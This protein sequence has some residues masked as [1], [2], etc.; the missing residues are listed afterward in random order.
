VSDG[1]WVALS[2]AVAQERALSVTANN[3]ANAST[4]GFRGDR[5]S[6]RET[7]SQAGVDG[8][9]PQTLRFVSTSRVDYDESAG[10]LRET[11]NPLD[12]ALEGDGWFAIRTP[13]G[14]RYT[15][16]GSFTTDGQ[17]VL[18]T[19]DGHAVLGRPEREGDPAPEIVL[20]Q[21]EAEVTVA[22]DGTIRSGEQAVG[23]L[24]LVRFAEGALTK[25]GHTRFTANGQPQDAY[26][27]N[28]VRQGMLEQANVNAVAGMHELITVSRSFEAFQKVIDTFQQLD[29]RTARELGKQ[30]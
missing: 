28:A 29:E 19:P 12:V 9:A 17:G 4:T 2:G 5:V 27:G 25:E 15:R 20:P 16:A 11:G 3:V 30:R 10:A 7:L 6:F 13:E 22:S 26:D 21:T 18:R 8:P 24:W 23:Q 1:I 14:E